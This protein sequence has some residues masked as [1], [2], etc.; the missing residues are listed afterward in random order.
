MTA[1]LC[2][3]LTDALIV[4]AAGSWD[5]EVVPPMGILVAFGVGF[6]N[7]VFSRLFLVAISIVSFVII[8]LPP[9]DYLSTMVEELLAQGEKPDG[10]RIAMLR[11]QFQRDAREIEVAEYEPKMNVTP[12]A[13][14]LKDD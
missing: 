1:L 14:A 10:E 4:A 8:Q 13:V 2:L 12:N 3:L 5:A 6:W 9:G 11:E 7:L